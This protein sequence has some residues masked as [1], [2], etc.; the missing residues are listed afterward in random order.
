MPPRIAIPLPLSNDSEYVERS[1]PQYEAAVRMAGGETVRIPL[2]LSGPELKRVVENCDGVLLPGSKT[3]V[4][5]AK[6]GA[7]KHQKT[8]PPDPRRDYVDCVLLEDAYANGKPVLGICYGLQSLNVY[9]AGTLIQH[10]PDFLQPQ[11]RVVNHAAGRAVAVAHEA[12]IDGASTLAKIIGDDARS[13]PVTIPVNSSHHQSAEN[14]GT[15]L[16]VVARCPTDGIIEALEGTD[17]DHFIV[18]VQWHPERSVEKDE[19]SRAIFRAFV[20]ASSR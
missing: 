3:D 11:L 16:R 4:D 20:E 19:P 2:D 9:R 14:P 6:Y 1:L 18:A 15:G 5:P 13:A 10:I 7:S 8:A 12:Q 17:P